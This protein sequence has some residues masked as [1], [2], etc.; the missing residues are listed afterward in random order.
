M[1][2]MSMRGR[3]SMKRYLGGGG[4]EPLPAGGVL[5]VHHLGDRGLAEGAQGGQGHHGPAPGQSAKAPG[6]NYACY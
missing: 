4:D 5:C 2:I 3:R 1:R 6:V